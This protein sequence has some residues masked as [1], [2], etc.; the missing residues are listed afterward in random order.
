MTQNM[1]RY[2]RKSLVASTSCLTV[3]HRRLDASSAH[4]CVEIPTSE[5]PARTCYSIRGWSKTTSFVK[6]S[7]QRIIR[8]RL[9]ISACPSGTKMMTIS[10]VTWIAAA[11]INTIWCKDRRS[12]RDRVGYFIA[13][14][15]SLNDME[16][17]CDDK[18]PLCVWD[19]L[20][21]RWRLSK[22]NKLKIS[23][24]RSEESRKLFRVES[25]HKNLFFSLHKLKLAL[26]VNSQRNFLF[27]L[28]RLSYLLH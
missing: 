8:H 22:R 16:N 28:F 12:Q 9:M 11:R 20:A 24:N 2:L 10:I 23:H 14:S 1:H 27:L 3:F 15:N 25:F 18:E 5:S 6:S 17:I 13:T 4:C 7:I 21:F 26:V 19:K